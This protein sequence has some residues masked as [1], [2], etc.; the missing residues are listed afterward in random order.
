MKKLFTGMI[1]LGLAVLVFSNADA[2]YGKR[3]GGGC[4]N[5]SQAEGPTDQYRKFQNDTI[6]LRQEMMTKRFEVQRENLKGTPDNAKI[7]T[8]QADIKVI[9]SKLLAIRT[10]SGLPTD[11]CDGECAQA[12]AGCGKKT[13]GGGCNNGPCGS[14]K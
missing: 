12:G 6:D 7:A 1:A 2:G 3:M 11:K 4:G 13:M 5:C 9:Q 10:Q 14:Q 8:L